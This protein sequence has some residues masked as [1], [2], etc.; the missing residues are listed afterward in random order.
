VA[1]YLARK[2][3]GY[4]IK[5]LAE[6]FNRDPVVMSQG[7]MKVERKLMTDGAFQQTM[8]TLEEVLTRNRKKRI[9]L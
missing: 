7:I 8:T 3:G 5:A 1:G 6:H 2:L 9:L 4:H